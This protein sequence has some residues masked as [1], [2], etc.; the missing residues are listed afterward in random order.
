M[1]TLTHGI[2]SWDLAAGFGFSKRERICLTWL[3]IAPDVDGFGAPMEILSKGKIPLFS[4]LHHTFGHTLWTALILM[5][6]A[7]FWCHKNKKCAL[8]AGF[9]VHF[10][11]LCDLL[12]SKG[13]DGS[14]WGIPYLLPLSTWELAWENQ[15][16]LNA[17][18]NIFLT[19]IALAFMF[20]TAWRYGNSMVEL[21]SKKGNDLFVQTL[22]L[23]FGSPGSPIRRRR[24]Q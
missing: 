14:I 18:Q 7:Y 23:R 3:S 24:G 8:F 4:L 16:A 5:G 2:L 22:R 6:V 9:L 12:G 10:H 20:Y 21:F 19:L 1:H 11:F 13:P 17:P 15:W